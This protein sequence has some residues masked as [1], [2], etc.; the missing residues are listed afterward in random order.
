[1]TYA[2]LFKIFKAYNC[3]L[4]K[5]K[6][7]LFNVVA[8]NEVAL[9]EEETILQWETLKIS[10]TFEVQIVFNNVLKLF[11]FNVNAIFIDESRWFI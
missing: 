2:L 5:H 3:F 10:K 9:L 11:T 1:M 6:A 8:F 4:S 7:S